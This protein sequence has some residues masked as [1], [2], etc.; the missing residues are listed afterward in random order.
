[1]P[2]SNLIRKKGR[3]GLQRRRYWLPGYFDPFYYY[4]LDHVVDWSIWGFSYKRTQRIVVDPISEHEVLSKSILGVAINYW[5]R[6]P[7]DPIT[8]WATQTFKCPNCRN[9]PWDQ[10]LPPA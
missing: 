8:P 4:T 9:W 1:M 10:S 6:S 3:L 5:N 7:E 2:S